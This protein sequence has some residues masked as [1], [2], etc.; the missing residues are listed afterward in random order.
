M[1]R[2]SIPVGVPITTEGSVFLSRFIGA[3]FSLVE[4]TLAFRLVFKI[5]GAD[6]ANIFVKS[7]YAVTQ[8]FVGLFEGIFPVTLTTIDSLPLF[9][10]AT[11]IAMLV[12]G[13]VGIILMGLVRPRK[14]RPEWI[15]YNPVD[16]A[17]KSIDF[18]AK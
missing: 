12:V 9:E 16:L 10:P 7:I 4:V 2:K 3:L 11:L 15:E 6:P 1:E 18:P 5:L 17:D 13:V 8:F 14:T